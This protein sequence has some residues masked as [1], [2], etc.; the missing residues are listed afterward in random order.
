M[1]ERDGLSRRHPLVGFLFFAL[2]LGF[3]MCLLHPLSLLSSFCGALSY[4]AALRGAPAARRT[5][6]RLLPLWLLAALLNPAFNHAGV[7]VL[8]Y[9]PSGN[10]LTAESLRFGLAAAGMLVAVLLWFACCTEVMTEDKLLCLFGRA[11][12]ALA[13]TLSAALRFVPRFAAVFRAV[14]ETQRVNAA[15]E[16]GGVLARF[17]SGAAAFSS[18]TTWALEHGIETADGMRGRGYGLPGRT[19]FSLYVFTARDRRVLSWLLFCAAGLLTL[20]LLG[21]FSWRCFPRVVRA[22]LDAP[23]VLAQL[24]YLAL[25]LTP[26]FL[27]GEEG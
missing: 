25:C 12:P 5:L 9:L 18:V 20:A 8:A 17:R 21:R 27:R 24:W 26:L 13:L 16:E 11:S 19:S 23:G 22:P 1:N 3:S 6:L 15:A 14:R 10:P 4:L 2:V 7:T